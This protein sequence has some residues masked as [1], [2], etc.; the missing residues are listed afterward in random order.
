MIVA[1][2]G[3]DFFYTYTM[4]K[5]YSILLLL[6]FLHICCHSKSKTIHAEKENK[7]APVFFP[8][9]FLPQRPD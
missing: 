8:G 9:D 2:V 6:A 1:I 3:N 7:P 4:T 5:V